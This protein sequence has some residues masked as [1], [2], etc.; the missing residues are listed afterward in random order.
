M[1]MPAPVIPIEPR[2]S[3]QII[4]RLLERRA[5]LKADAE[6]ITG[7]VEQIDSQLLELLGT[8]GT[9]DVAG[10]KVEVR[11]YTRQDTKWIEEEYPVDQYPQLYK[12]TTAVDP[13][14]VK[15][16]FAPAVLDAHKVHGKKSVVVK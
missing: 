7:E 3:D 9:H 8:V 15:R 14:A 6:F 11:Q 5:T 1:S 2:K 4:V 10:V 12:V 13:E 16:E